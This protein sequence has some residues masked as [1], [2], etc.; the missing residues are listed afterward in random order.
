MAVCMHSLVTLPL[1][2]RPLHTTIAVWSIS[3]RFVLWR[4]VN[5]YRLLSAS[6]TPSEPLPLYWSYGTCDASCAT[7]VSAGRFLSVLPTSLCVFVPCSRCCLFSL[8]SGR[9]S[10]D[11][12]RRPRLGRVSE[13]RLFGELRGRF[14]MLIMSRTLL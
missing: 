14:V 11:G 8:S 1:V 2:D 3:G 7:C 9:S 5:T 12:E 13:S 6:H 10:S 4:Y